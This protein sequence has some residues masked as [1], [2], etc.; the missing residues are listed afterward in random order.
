MDRCAILYHG[1]SNLVRIEGNLNSNRY[2]REVLQPEVTPLLQGI[3][4]AT[5]QQDNVHLHVVKTVRDFCS[6]QHMQLL[7]WPAY[8]LDMLP[9]EQVG[10]WDDLRLV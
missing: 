7:P 3:H 8:S 4:V 1:R 10:V 6:G 2:V 5:F 9:I